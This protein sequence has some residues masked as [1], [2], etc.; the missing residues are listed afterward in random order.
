MQAKI[1]GP[2]FS[3]KSDTPWSTALWLGR[4]TEADEIIVALPDGVRKVRTIR[5]LFRCIGSI[6]ET[7]VKGP[8][9]C[10]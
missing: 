5:R 4:D 7:K 1:I 6:A 10:S 3:R 2:K 9:D 8:C